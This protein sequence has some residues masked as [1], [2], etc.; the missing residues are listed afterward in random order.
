MHGVATAT[1]DAL[2]VALGILAKRF[3][4]SSLGPNGAS[5]QTGSKV[6]EMFL[7]FYRIPTSDQLLHFGAKISWQKLGE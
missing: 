1:C 3:A 5:H 6:Y 4:I 2:R 7:A